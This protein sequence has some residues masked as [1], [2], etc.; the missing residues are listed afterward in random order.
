MARKQGAWS[1]RPHQGEG[2][3]PAS[4]TEQ[5]DAIVA[6]LRAKRCGLEARQSSQVE[7]YGSQYLRDASSDGEAQLRRCVKSASCNT[8]SKSGRPKGCK[9]LGERTHALQTDALRR[10]DPAKTGYKK[11]HLQ[12]RPTLSTWALSRRQALTTLPCC[13]WHSPCHAFFASCHPARSHPMP[14][15]L[16]TAESPIDKVIFCLAQASC[17]QAFEPDGDPDFAHGLEQNA[18]G[19]NNNPCADKTPLGPLGRSI[20][21]HQRCEHLVDACPLA[22]ANCS[23]VPQACGDQG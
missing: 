6:L 12:C 2:P 16:C 17:T 23:P 10:S 20:L 9:R 22:C 3:R 7:N 14:S 11:A 5:C 4:A 18:M 21:S 1:G 15:A 19:S 13:S 8:S